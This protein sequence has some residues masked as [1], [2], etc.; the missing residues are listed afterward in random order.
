MRAH[1][2]VAIVVSILLGLGLKLFVFSAP[3]AGTNATAKGGGM[4]VS[5]MHEGKTLP[6]ATMHDMTFVYSDGD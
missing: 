4:D 1:Y 2:A 3:A 6:R 5:K